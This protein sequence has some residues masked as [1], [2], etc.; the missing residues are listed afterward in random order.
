MFLV[1]VDAHAKWPE[2]ALMKGTSSEKMVEALCS[3]FSHFGLPQQLVSD[4]CPR[5][6][7]E[8]FGKFME[9]NG[10][11]HIKSAPYHPATN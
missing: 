6:V 2:V 11:Q 3:I 5:L 4:N 1:V 10:I 7:S 8:E 9:D